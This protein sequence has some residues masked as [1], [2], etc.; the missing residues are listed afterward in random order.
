MKKCKFLLVCLLF[1]LLSGI[2]QEIVAQKVVFRDLTWEQAVALAEKEGKV[3]LVDAMMKPR[4][5]KAKEAKAKMERDIFKVK[6]VADF[7]KEH[8]VAIRIDMGS[9]AGQAFA[10]KLVMNM[11]PTYGFFMPNG[12]ILGVASPFVLA[13][14]PQV[15]VQKGEEALK[16]AVTKRANSRSI[17]FEKL[18]FEEALKKAEKEKKL[19]FIDAHTAWS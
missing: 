8:T 6:E 5:A 9:E 11:Y 14:D 18:T 4:D 12:D 7:V 19:V 13:K 17:V 16:M 2:R 3:V 10:P 15:L 1:C